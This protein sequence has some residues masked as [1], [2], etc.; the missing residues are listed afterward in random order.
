MEMPKINER[1]R[2]LVDYY[3]NRSVKKFAASINM[4]QQTINRLFNIDT[5]TGKYPLATTEILI[6]IT[7]MYVDI[8]ANWLLAGRGDMF[9]NQISSVIAEENSPIEDKLLFIIKEKDIEIKE[10]A[11]EIGRLEERVNVLSK[12]SINTTDAGD[13][14]CVAAGE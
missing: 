5:R 8:D 2:Q 4:P 10:Q 14:I 7:E 1:V 11:K 3:A 9:I 6:S 13:V 12:K